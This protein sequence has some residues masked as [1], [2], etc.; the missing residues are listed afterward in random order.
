MA[1]ACYSPNIVGGT[2]NSVAVLSGGQY[3]GTVAPTLA[4]SDISVTAQATAAIMPFA[5]QGSA[6]ETYSGHVWVANGA[7]VYFSAPGS[8]SDFATSDGGGNFT[9]NDSYLRVG[10]TQ[11]INT[12]GFLWLIADSSV[13]Y[14]SGVQTTGVSPTTTYTKQNA[15]PQMGTPYPASVETFGH[16]I[17]MANAVGVHVVTGSNVTKI[18]EPLDGVWNSVASFGGL[19]LSA[20]QCY[21]FGKKMW[22]VLSEIVNPISGA[23]ENKLFLWHDKKWFPSSQDMTLTYI[24][25]Q[26]IQ[27]VITAYGTDGTVIRPLFTTPSVAFQK[28]VQSKL[29]DA[30]GSYLFTKEAGRVWAVANYTSTLSPNITIKIDAVDQ[31][32]GASSQTYTIT[33]PVGTGYFISPPQAIGQVGQLTGMTIQTNAADMS[34]ASVAIGEEIV[35]YRG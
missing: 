34:L 24:K 25:H 29:W 13:D 21:V 20:S 11:L 12:N 9:S 23:T 27:S 2:I 15:D 10:Y 26:E 19:Q 14:I 35:Q 18:S 8:F 32:A 7:T 6:V 30:P 16:D 4:V 28:T 5:I 3:G 31:T 22:A 17:L 1:Q 33:G